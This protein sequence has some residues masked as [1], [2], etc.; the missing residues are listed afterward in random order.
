MR[1]RWV[2]FLLLLVVYTSP[3][4]AQER[5]PSPEFAMKAINML[6]SPRTVAAAKWD[7][8]L[9]IKPHIILKAIASAERKGWQPTDVTLFRAMG[10]K[11]TRTDL[12]RVSLGQEVSESTGDGEMMIW[13]WDDGDASTVE[14]TAYFLSY[15]SGYSVTFN[16]QYSG[17]SY[18]DMYVAWEEPIHAEGPPRE[19][20]QIYGIRGTPRFVSGAGFR[21]VQDG[22]SCDVCRNRLDNAHWNRCNFEWQSAFVGCL[23]RAT[24]ER[25]REGMRGAAVGAGVEGA[26]GCFVGSGGGLAGCAAGTAAGLVDGAS[27]GFIAGVIY[28]FIW[29]SDY[30]CGREGSRAYDT[31][32][33]RPVDYSSCW[34][35]CLGAQ[36]ATVDRAVDVE[37]ILESYC[38]DF[39]RSG[40]AVQVPW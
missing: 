33:A 6:T 5:G 30:E 10:T 2:A 23:Q 28:S 36:H 4:Q 37:A 1:C 9:A 35:Y 18:S 32:M 13:N 26:I 21:W 31:C 39:R 3:A 19:E 11:R 40:S 24:G 25:F 15:H 14:G 16:A 17:T 20:P 38:R 8:L 29:G 27:K 34:E 22:R 12:R 7:E